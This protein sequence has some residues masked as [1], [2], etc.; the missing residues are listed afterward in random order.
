MT[1]N[2]REW[3]K[4]TYSGGGQNECVE[5]RLAPTVGV[6]DTK[7]RDNGHLTLSPTAWAAFLTKTAQH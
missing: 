5:V 3:R 4:S 7:D 1:T 6:R 2:P